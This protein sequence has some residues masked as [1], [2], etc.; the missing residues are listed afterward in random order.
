MLDHVH[1]ML[2]FPDEFQISPCMNKWKD[3]TSRQIARTYTE[4]FSKYWSGLEE[5]ETVWQPRYY[6]F[7][8]YSETK[9]HEK[10]EYIHNNPVRAGLVKEIC[11]W[12]WSSARAWHQGKSVGIALSWPP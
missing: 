9:V 12:P 11:D 3:L 8:I 10:L 1:A 7:N 2:W 4:F 6:D 5:R